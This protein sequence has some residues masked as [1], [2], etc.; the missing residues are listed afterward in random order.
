MYALECNNNRVPAADDAD[1]TE[2]MNHLVGLDVPTARLL[3]DGEASALAAFRARHDAHAD[4]EAAAEPQWTI[5]PDG[6][7]P[8]GW[9]PL[10]DCTLLRFLRADRRAGEF[11]ADASQSRLLAALAWRRQL[12]LDELLAV[13]P[14]RH[15]EYME[16]RVRRWV[17]VDHEYRPVQFERLGG[18]LA[19]GNVRA[20]TPDEWLVHYARDVEETFEKM[21][22]AARAS[23]APVCGYVFCADLDGVGLGLL[24]QLRSVV[25]LLKLLTKEVQ[26]CVARVVAARADGRRAVQVLLRRHR[27]PH[28]PSVLHA[29][30]QPHRSPVPNR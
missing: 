12:R 7:P 27:A 21:R 11:N 3:K 14:P 25:P 23:G 22:G 19:S 8:S 4:A 17:G 26:A 5:E 9:R 28:R 15:D 29:P 18:F 20:F 10:D 2:S 16:L 13:P 24:G 30:R 6:L 1:I